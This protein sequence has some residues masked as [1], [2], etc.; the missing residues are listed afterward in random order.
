[1]Y[2]LSNSEI[3]HIARQSNSLGPDLKIY[4]VPEQLRRALEVIEEL[5]D[6][7]QL[8]NHRSNAEVAYNR[9][10]EWYRALGPEVTEP[11][12]RLLMKVGGLY[13]DRGLGDEAERCY[14]EIF[15]DLPIDPS[16]NNTLFH[17]AIRNFHTK[18]RV[19]QE[20]LLHTIRCCPPCRFKL[21]N[22]EYQTPLHL[23]V[24]TATEE[25]AVAILVRLKNCHRQSRI[26][27][28]HLDAR[29]CRG[30]TILST[31]V[32]AQC[33][34]PLINALI[35]HGSEVNPE[36]LMDGRYTPLQAA[37]R[38]GS[39]RID[40]ASLLLRHRANPNHV[41]P[42]STIAQLMVEDRLP[43]VED[44]PLIPKLDQPRADA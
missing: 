9:L 3:F 2:E 38:P 26:D 20:A 44:I 33:S 39:E 21:R 31:A 24:S 25:V 10:I 17:H 22:A 11:R 13:E 1:M 23:A 40:I 29:D 12:Q 35:V 14:L 36:I 34:L 32:L 27:S 7:A 43:E 8:A 30:Q 41:D 42:Y 19:S 28:L 18:G 4:I 15:E 6:Q 16:D 5:A 37:S